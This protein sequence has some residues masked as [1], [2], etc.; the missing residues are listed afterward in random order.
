MQTL[1]DRRRA[2]TM[3]AAAAA[4]AATDDAVRESEPCQKNQEP[5][6]GPA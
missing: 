2:E 6:I 4:A 1:F 5:T 3:Q